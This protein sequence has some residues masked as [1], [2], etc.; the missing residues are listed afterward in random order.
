MSRRAAATT[1]ALVAVIVLVA[2][3]AA[4]A[5][6]APTPLAVHQPAAV[7]QPT[8]VPQPAA[9]PSVF[10]P[11]LPLAAT[12]RGAFPG[13]LGPGAEGP[14]V[15]LVQRRLAELRIDPGA[16]DGHAGDSTKY[17]VYALQKLHGIEP[18]G[19]VDQATWDALAGPTSVTP[20]VPTGAPDRIEVDVDAQL[21]VVWDDDRVELV[22]HISTGS[23]YDYC[24]EGVCGTAITPRGSYT[25]QRRI[26]GWRIARL[27]GLY[28]PL[29]F[30]GGFAL[31]GSQSVPTHPASH[32]CVRLPMHVADLVPAMVPNGEEVYV[33][34]AE[35]P[36]QPLVDPARVQV[37]AADPF[38]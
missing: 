38:A 29:Y 25:V 11:P 28:N 15:E 21:M 5:E 20:R 31:H 32:G 23:G 37:P 24:E 9:A 2:P 19:V 36:P 30:W 12:M 1:V 34:D 10:P 8:A 7:P 18:T 4:V 13:D 35:H 17:A 6:P 22:S 16:I 3:G 33:F 26:P 14:A 27:G